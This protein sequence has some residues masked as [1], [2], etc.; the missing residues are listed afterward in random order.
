MVFK[1]FLA[2]TFLQPFLSL[3]K[4]FV[5]P[6]IAGI[7]ICLVVILLLPFMEGFEENQSWWR[8]L[9]WP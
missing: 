6:T 8:F 5:C 7:I 4:G 3:H 1:Y 2:V 9:D